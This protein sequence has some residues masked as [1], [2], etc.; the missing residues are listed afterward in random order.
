MLNTHAWWIWLVPVAVLTL[1]A[2]IG[3]MIY[4]RPRRDDEPVESVEQYERFRSAMD[5]QLT[6]RRGPRPPAEPG[7]K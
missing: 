4:A 7:P 3:V 1:L 2:I 6:T 5:S